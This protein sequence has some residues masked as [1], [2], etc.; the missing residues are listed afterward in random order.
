[1]SLPYRDPD[2]DIPAG[3]RNEGA[4]A[5]I[6]RLARELYGADPLD[7]RM[8]AGKDEPFGGTETQRLARRALEEIPYERRLD[9]IFRK[10]PIKSEDVLDVDGG[11]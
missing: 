10:A 7:V 3:P 4:S 1:M 2:E 5:K 9:D 8:P 11:R 6:M